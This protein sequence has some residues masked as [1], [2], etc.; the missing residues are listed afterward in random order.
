MKRALAN[1]VVVITGGSSGIGHAT[2]LAFA[3]CKARVVIAS[4]SGEALGRVLRE[5]KDLGAEAL[6]VP[7]DVSHFDDVQRIARE[8]LGRFG[9]IDVWINNAAVAEWALIEEMTP[10]EMRRV[11]DVNVLGPM[12]GVRVALPH[13][14]ETNGVIINVASALA[15]RAIPLLSTYSASKAAVKSFSDS[16]RMELRDSGANV[17]VVTIL[18][19]SINTPFYRWG[20]SKLGV[21]P[22][23]VS[24][25]YPPRLVA[26]AM[27]SAAQRPQREIFVGVMGKLLSIAE[28]ISPAAMDWYMLQRRNMFR[29]QYSAIEDEGESNLF[30]TPDESA[31]DGPFVDETRKTSVYTKAVELRPGMRR[32]IAAGALAA[33]FA[34]LAQRVS[35]RSRAGRATPLRPL[36]RLRAWSGRRR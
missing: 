25:I 36:A 7:A 11:I 10:D 22:H 20:P 6:A 18:P 34:L 2:A 14:K 31:I 32:V 4:R 35:R 13:L 5:I 27:V 1:A 21:R 26:E 28:R 16:L 17:D 23:P 8:A 30:R 33:A 9:R 12:Y 29:Q 3:R 19:S 24:V 15:D